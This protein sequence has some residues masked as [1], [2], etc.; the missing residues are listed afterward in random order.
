VEER[1]ELRTLG[2]GEVVG[3]LALLEGG[4]RSASVEAVV[5][6]TV[7][8]FDGAS[9]RD[10]LR[11]SPQFVSTVLGNLAQY[12]RTNTERLVRNELEQRAIRA[13]MEVERLRSLTQMV[14]GVAHELN[15]PLGII[16]TA[17]SIIRQRLASGELDDVLEAGRTHWSPSP[18]TY[19]PPRRK[20]R[21]A[22][23][24]LFVPTLCARAKTHSAVGSCFNE[25]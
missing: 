22:S 18:R 17:S 24:Q 20:S 7:F 3:E 15:T 19:H 13:E 11:N 10:L 16:Q 23:H 6:S 12:V 21:S 9:F 14:A 1:V 25:V 4:R 8:A 2:P 5:E